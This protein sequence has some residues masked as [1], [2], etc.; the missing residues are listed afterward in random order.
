MQAEPR[1]TRAFVWVTAAAYL[2][3]ISVYLIYWDH[4]EYFVDDWFLM[5]HFRQAAGL[6][7]VA[8]FAASAAE[9]R[10][11][12]VFRMQWL[13]ILYGFLV[14]SAGGY[15]AKFN[16]AAL[17]LLH[18]VC[19]WLLCQAL[20][21]L[22]LD[23]SLAFLA[24]ALYLLKPTTHFGLVTYLTNPFFV[25]STFW[26]LLLLWWFAGRAST[27]YWSTG[28]LLFAAGCAIA[29]LFSG[30]QVFLLLWAI[31][32][33]AVWCFPR[34]SPA[35]RVWP[36]IGV[37][38]AALTAALSV[39]L[40][41]INR[42]PVRQTGTAR[43]FEWGWSR[44][45]SNLNQI[46]DEMRRL[47]GLTSDSLFR[48]SL[49]KTEDALALAAAILVAALM[50][51]WHTDRLA[52]SP[53]SP[54]PLWRVLL[55]GYV[56]AALAYGPVMWVAGG[57][58]RFRYHYVPTPYL[59]VGAAGVIGIFGRSRWTRWAPAAI[60]GLAAG[61]LVFNAAADLRQ[62]WIPQSQEQRRLEAELRK[63]SDL[64]PGDTL[65]ISGTPAQIGTAQHFSMH[66]PLSATPFAE[67]AT[68]VT[69]LEVH[70]DLWDLHG[71][72]ITD[73]LHYKVLSPEQLGRTH[74][75][76]RSSDGKFLHPAW[77]AAEAAP[78]QFRI[79]PLKGASLPEGAQQAVFSAEQ[80]V[81]LPSPVYFAKPVG[82]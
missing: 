67:W 13:S 39:Y 80:L 14:T 26:V 47:S 2:F 48:F 74:V 25:F 3:L 59:A 50:W 22:A 42:L 1:E 62:C 33:L 7:G 20:R 82:R 6:R 41:L 8:G 12:Q 37:V 49:N 70:L 46:G 52:P 81:R 78:G 45:L 51:R 44:F 69:P 79:I 10:V 77:L 31:L 15:S 17:L 4:V 28:A 30:E 63:L 43:R 38:W 18:V 60:G 57:F 76:M 66:S 29:G 9:N 53:A 75:L 71:R 36:V 27:P 34:R 32:P 73:P 23:R 35:G 61:L 24:G 58:P 55:F 65:V 64:A 21:R 40:L 11:Y 72:V 54:V 68:G 5:R 56:G 16:F 19:A